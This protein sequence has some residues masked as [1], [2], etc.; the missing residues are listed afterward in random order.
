MLAYEYGYM[1][2]EMGRDPY[3]SRNT[4]HVTLR[5]F[6]RCDSTILV[7]RNTYT[8]TYIHTYIYL[9]ILLIS[10]NTNINT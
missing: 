10:N 1:V 6:C 2:C 4:M 3:I 7:V 8:C 5:L 9:S